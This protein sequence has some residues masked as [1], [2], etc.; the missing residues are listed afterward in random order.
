MEA[1]ATEGDCEGEGSISFPFDI[2]EIEEVTFATTPQAIVEVETTP[3]ISVPPHE[4]GSATM[5]PCTTPSPS[6][7]GRSSALK[8]ARRDLDEDREG[9]LQTLR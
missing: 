8:R 6:G 5:S 7:S 1:P 2:T 4:S 3:V 9:L